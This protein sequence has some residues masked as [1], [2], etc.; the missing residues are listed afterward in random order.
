MIS[1]IITTY[2]ELETLKRAIE[3]ILSQIKDFD[4]EI[5][6]VGPDEETEKVAENFKREIGPNIRYLKDEGKGKPAALNLAFKKAKG[7]FL[8]LTDGD[9][10]IKEGS[11]KKLIEPLLK[12]PLV[13]LVSGRPIPIN[14]KD[15][16]FGYWAHFL[17]EA[18]HLLRKS[19]NNW[20]AS[21]YLYAV[22]NF[23]HKE[24]VLKE[25]DLIEDATITDLVRKKN[26]LVVYAPEAEV[27]VKFPTNFRDWLKQKVR[28]VGGYFQKKDF[29]MR[30]FTLEIKNA[31]YLFFTYPKSLKEFFWTLLLY[32]ARIYLWCLIFWQI[33]IKKRKFADLWKRIESTK[34][35]NLIF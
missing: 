26:Y 9:V 4:Y 2:R 7:D 12:N 20:P 24:E 28:S 11:L 18:A 32:L 35:F 23:F 13:G 5:L 29:K 34:N 25:D 27:C 21:G 10:F 3:A 16:L 19:K 31:L 6:I 8:I 14:S 30:S 33:K 1:V 17:T 15:N 22:K